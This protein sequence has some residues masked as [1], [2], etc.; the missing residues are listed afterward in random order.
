MNISLI[1]HKNLL[2]CLGFKVINNICRNDIDHLLFRIIILND[3]AKN[4][5]SFT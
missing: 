5:K 1:R 4:I 3:K 2:P